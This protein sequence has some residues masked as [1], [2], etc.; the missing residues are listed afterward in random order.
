VPSIDRPSAE[1]NLGP[2][3][4]RPHWRRAFEPIDPAKGI[5]PFK[6]ARLMVLSLAL[7]FGVA[8]R[9]DGKAARS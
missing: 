4:L 7:K 2:F 3:A 1:G 5:P 6:L 8:W 9:I